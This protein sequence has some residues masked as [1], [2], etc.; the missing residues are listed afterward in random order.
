[1]QLEDS[2]QSEF[3]V[4]IALLCGNVQLQSMI[5]HESDLKYFMK[6]LSLQRVAFLDACCVTTQ[7]TEKIHNLNMEANSFAAI[8]DTSSTAD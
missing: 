5:N 7:N 2:T 4:K 3:L 6:N 8:S 1:L